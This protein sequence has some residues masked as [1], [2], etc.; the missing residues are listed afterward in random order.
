MN[1]TA[2]V[3]DDCGVT[4]VER[5]PDQTDLCPV[6]RTGGDPEQYPPLNQERGDYR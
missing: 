6:C 4:I 3:C 5:D 1:G 2:Y